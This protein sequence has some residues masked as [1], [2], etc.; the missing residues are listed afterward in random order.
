MGGTAAI[1]LAASKLF[2]LE[3]R[4]HT[5]LESGSPAERNVVCS[6]QR[7]VFSTFWQL[8]L[9]RDDPAYYKDPFP[10][11]IVVPDDFA[12]GLPRERRCAA[13]AA[14]SRGQDHERESM[15]VTPW[16]EVVDG[17]LDIC[18]SAIEALQALQSI[19]SAIDLREHSERWERVGSK[20]SRVVEVTV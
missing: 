7:C 11:D 20:R 14:C 9:L 15:V 8:L 18:K 1:H 16:R 5:L 17:C 6:M 3:M 4:L 12:S 13:E 19:R 2:T 10:V